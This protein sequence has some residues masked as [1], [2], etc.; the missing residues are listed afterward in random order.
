MAEPKL[1]FTGCVCLSCAVSPRL[2]TV[3]PAQVHVAWFICHRSVGASHKY[4]ADVWGFSHL[5]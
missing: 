1:L 3:L 5:G 2:V 4:K